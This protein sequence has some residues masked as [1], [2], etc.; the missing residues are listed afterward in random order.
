MSQYPNDHYDDGFVWALWLVAIIILVIVV[1][2]YFAWWQPIYQQA[3]IIQPN[4]TYVT[5]AV[6]GPQGEQGQ[7]GPQGPVGKPG[8]PGPAGPPG[9]STSPPTTPL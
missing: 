8:P 2:G 4:N 6:P 9:Q 3:P 1:I 7:Q 5:P